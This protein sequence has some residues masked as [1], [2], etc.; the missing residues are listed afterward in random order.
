MPPGDLPWESPKNKNDRRDYDSG[1]GKF[2]SILMAQNDLLGSTSNQ[3]PDFQ[4]LGVTAHES[5]GYGPIY[6]GSFEKPEVL[7]LAD[8]ESE[9]DLFSTRAL[10]GTG[11]QR[12]QTFLTNLNLRH[13]YL[14]I[15]TLPV[16]TLDLS[17]DK[18]KQ[19]ALN[20]DVAA[21]R[22]NIL[23]AILNQNKTKLILTIGPIAAE[24]IKNLNTKIPI[25]NLADSLAANHVTEWQKSADDI[26]ALKI[27]FKKSATYNGELTAIPRHDLPIHTRWWMGTS[28][29]R[30]SRA[31]V[32][33][34]LGQIWNGDYYKFESPSWVNTINYPAD[35]KLLSISENKSL[36]LFTLDSEKKKEFDEE[37]QQITEAATAVETP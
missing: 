8:Q 25:L 15:R 5:F 22:K 18:T 26:I 20:S 30:A 12:L 21:V 1:P 35:P 23:M 14:I 3:W 9:D 31:Y 11:G 27:G 6:R 33:T 24:A 13:K 16:D 28:G 10:T 36:K 19:I 17:P 37:A 29:S 2:S 4:S 7:I 32:K 34:K